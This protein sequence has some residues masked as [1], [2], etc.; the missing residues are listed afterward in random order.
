MAW[1]WTDDLARL[2]IDHDHVP[3]ER[4]ASWLSVPSAYRSDLEPLAFA[5]ELFGLD[6]PEA[7]SEGSAT[8]A[9]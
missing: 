9:A 7:S 1:Y 2:V 5:R 3:P 8:T 6:A 4:L